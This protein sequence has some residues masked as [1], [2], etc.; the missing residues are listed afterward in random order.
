MHLAPAPSRRAAK[1]WERLQKEPGFLPCARC[2]KSPSQPPNGGGDCFLTP[3]H[4]TCSHSS[5]KW[6]LGPQ[7]MSWSQDSEGEWCQ[8][9][10]TG[11]AKEKQALIP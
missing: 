11:F 8:T 4:S 7:R 6:E 1:G 3:A 9:S 2:W 10:Q 5:G